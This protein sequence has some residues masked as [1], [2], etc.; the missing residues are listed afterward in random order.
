MALRLSRGLSLA[1]VVLNNN[2]AYT[3]FFEL[4]ELY[5]RELY[6]RELYLRELYLRELYLRELYLRELNCGS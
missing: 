4:W 2:S 1:L 3:S 6:L 5:L